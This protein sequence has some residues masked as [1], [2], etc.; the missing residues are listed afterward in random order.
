MD[1]LTATKLAASLVRTTDGLRALRRTLKAVV[2]IGPEP[3]R[4]GWS[5]SDRIVF[6]GGAQG[7]HSLDVGASSPARILAHWEGYRENNGLAARPTPGSCVRFPSA[8]A[9]Q[10]GGYRVGTVLAVGPKRARIAYT[11]KHG[12]K[13][14]ATVPIRD[15]RF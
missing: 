4:V 1:T 13:A 9:W 6:T 8:S 15:L 5:R 10:A 7:T 3:A 12:G 2:E 11:F 14:E